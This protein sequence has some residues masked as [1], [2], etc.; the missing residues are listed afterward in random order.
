MHEACVAPV[1]GFEEAAAHPHNV[2]RGAFVTAGGVTQPAPAP[3][4]SVSETVAPRMAGA[5]DG[6]AILAEAG[7]A[8]AEIEALLG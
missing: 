5:Q 7:F 4:Y 2:S 1:L 6:A 8:P 3:R